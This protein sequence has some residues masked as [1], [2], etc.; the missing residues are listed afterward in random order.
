M[1]LQTTEGDIRIA[2]YDDTPIHRDNFLKMVGE[3]FYDSLLFHRV[4][5]GFMIQAGDPQSRH[6]EPGATLGEG[7]VDYTLQPEFLVPKHYH[8]RGA[9]AMAREGDKANPE[10]RSSGCQFYIVWGKTYSS[11][12]LEAIQ[13]KVQDAT[14]GKTAITSEMFW[15]YRKTGGSPHLDGQY[16]VFGEVVQGLDVVERIQRVYTDDYDRPV[17]DVRIIKAVVLK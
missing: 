8:R 7:D 13:Q 5:K 15:D 14:D 3:Q 16:T 4:I 9:V 1:L 17:E 10:R 6:A 12:E 2:L 11:K